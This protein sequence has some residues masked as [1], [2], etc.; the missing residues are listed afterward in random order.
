MNVFWVVNPLFQTHLENGRIVNLFTTCPAESMTYLWNFNSVSGK[1]CECNYCANVRCNGR[2]SKL[3]TTYPGKSL[4]KLKF[5]CCILT[6]VRMHVEFT[7]LVFNPLFLTPFHD[8][9]R[10]V[11]DV[12]VKFQLFILKTVWIHDEFM[13]FKW[14][15]LY[16]RPF[17][18]NGRIV[19]PST[20]CPGESSTFLWSLNSSSW[21]LCKCT[22]NSRFRVINP[23]F[24]TLRGER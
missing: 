24:S 18:G 21:K 2:I 11:F 10:E 8:L 13:F 19:N 15:T 14:L 6:T 12:P 7:F 20:T 9:S 3:S 17:G 22:S 16:F 1:L 5:Q 4:T 23:L